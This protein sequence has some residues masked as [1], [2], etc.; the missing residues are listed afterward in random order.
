MP[1]SP[2]HIGELLVHSD[3]PWGGFRTNCRNVCVH[4]TT[5]IRRMP[6]SI[7]RNSCRD[8]RRRG[9]KLRKRL[10]FSDCWSN[11]ANLWR[12]WVLCND[13]PSWLPCQ[14]CTASSVVCERVF[15]QSP[16]LD[17]Y[18]IHCNLLGTY[19][20]TITDLILRFD[21]AIS[22]ACRYQGELQNFHAPFRSQHIWNLW[23]P[24]Q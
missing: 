6:L 1:R 22:V 4:E 9:S 15:F 12:A 7:F 19:W 23:F 10:P 13:E 16:W 8:M 18:P 3:A 5:P 24:S 2:F 14:I 21:F 11:A 17:L 20:Q